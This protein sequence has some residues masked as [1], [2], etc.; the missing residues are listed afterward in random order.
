MRKSFLITSTV[1]VI[2]LSCV[3]FLQSVHAQQTEIRGFMDASANYVDDKLSFSL[4]EQDLFIT[5][6]ISDRISFLGE[7]VFKYSA[8][9]PTLFDVSMERVIIKYNY[10]GNHNLLIGKHHTPVNY[11]NDT[12][13]HGRV[14]FPTIFRPLLFSENIIPLHT[15]GL[16]L[17]GHD[18]GNLKFGYDCMI[19]NG[20]GSGDLTDNDKFKSITA[21]IHIKPMNNFH[22]G[23]SYYF[24]RISKGAKKP[25]STELVVSEITQQLISGYVSYFGRTVELLCEGT[26]A[27]NKSDSTGTANNIAAYGYA[28][29]RLFGKWVPYVRFDYLNFDKKEFYFH[30]DNTTAFIGGIRFEINYLAVV[31]LEFQ[32][33]NYK[34]MEDTNTIT[35]QFAL[36]F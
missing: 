16:S 19:G 13:H 32:H 8:P 17:S 36:G 5:S 18:F 29:Y 20:I 1:C 9:S 3:F 27:S 26:Y 23:G 7:T 14:F 15:T 6:S 33:T 21:A 24:D 2:F 31:K 25:H 30:N 34:L 11:W 35:A 22:I 4:G 10:T 28:G 12:Y